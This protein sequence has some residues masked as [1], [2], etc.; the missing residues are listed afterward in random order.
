MNESAN[1]RS[2]ESAKGRVALVTGA[3]RGIGRAIAVALAGD[4]W[5]VVVNYQANAEAAAQALAQVQAAG[6]QGVT[7][8]AD[9]ADAADRERLVQETLSRYGRIDLLVNNAGVAPRQR[10]DLLEATEASYDEVMAVNL[11]GPFFLTQRVAQVM[12]ALLA[13][14]AI[15]RPKIVNIGSISAYTSSTNRGEYCLSK[16]GIGMMTQLY[17]DRLAEYGINVYEV[18]PGIVET[19]MTSAVR[20]KYDRLIAAGLTPFRRWG[21]PEDVALA[22]QMIAAGR[23]PFSTGEVINVDGGFHL[24]RLP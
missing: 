1:Q 19:D 14:G 3:S 5:T 17:A 16:A 18:R 22:V 21:R 7:I 2:S 20:E 23:L 24:R 9:I 4:G 13:A 11:K 10:V 8:Q 12:I 15:Q 6:G